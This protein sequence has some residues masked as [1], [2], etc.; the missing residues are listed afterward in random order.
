MASHCKVAVF[1][2]YG[3][4]GR[5]IVAELVARG[6]TPI[7]AG[8]SASALVQMQESWPALTT[9]S[10]G[11]ESPAEL[12]AALAGADAVIN[13]AGPFS[14]TAVPVAEAALRA[15]IPYLDIVAEPD[16][17]EPLVAQ[18]DARARAAG[19][20]MAFAVGFYG[21]LGDLAAT[22]AM[23]DWREAD[24]VT[25]A[26]A[27]SSWKPTAG[28]RR[29]IEVAEERRGGQRLV[30]NGERFVLRAGS[31]PQSTWNFPAP[32]G[33]QS[34]VGEF[35][36]ADC[37]SLSRHLRI[38]RMHQ[39]MTV[40]PLGDLSDPD[41]SP[42]PAVDA[43]GRSA[44]TFLIEAVAVRGGQQRRAVVNGQDIYAVTAPLV[45]EATQRLLSSAPRP[46][47]AVS[48]GS[49]ANAAEFLAALSPAHLQ[50]TVS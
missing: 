17:A 26:Y 45:V 16:V 25:L 27:L 11:V 7:L 34:V 28:T 19:I 33:A 9:R 31:A 3:H 40:A 4:T 10:A 48:A 15:R 46:A 1:G 14:E 12:D 43:R 50:F 39:F 30:W 29:T 18:F 2:A 20:P 42:P 5:F 23:G 22:A 13:A 35:A 32:L 24:E 38:G 6:L 49:I 47:G 21:G 8:R 41:L 44:Q 36:T 37:V